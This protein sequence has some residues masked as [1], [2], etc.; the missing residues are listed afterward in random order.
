[1]NAI[2]AN[3]SICSGDGAI[4]EMQDDR[5]VKIIL[6][7]DVNETF[8][9]VYAIFGDTFDEVVD[10]LYTLTRLQSCGAL[11]GMNCF[12]GVPTMALSRTDWVSN[13]LLL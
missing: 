2:R 13:F 11:L 5:S 8:A 3:D 9:H 10:K 12:A 1:M 7:L 4:C 6:I